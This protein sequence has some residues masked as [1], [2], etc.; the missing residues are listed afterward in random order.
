MKEGMTQILIAI[1][2]L[3]S[4]A[5]FQPANLG[6]NGKHANH[7][8]IE[9]DVYVTLLTWHLDFLSA[10]L[11]LSQSSN[12]QVF[13]PLSLSLPSLMSHTHCKPAS[14]NKFILLFDLQAAALF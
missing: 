5:A 13:L 9:D 12:P 2:N 10:L 8:T 11:Y 6:S 4:L 1:K 14:D 3:S 7:H